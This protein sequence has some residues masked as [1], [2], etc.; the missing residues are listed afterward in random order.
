M[1]IIKATYSCALHGL[2]DRQHHQYWHMVSP[3]LWSPGEGRR[4][5]HLQPSLR[6]EGWVLLTRACLSLNPSKLLTKPLS[7]QCTVHVSAK[8]TPDVSSY[9]SVVVWI[10]VWPPREVSTWHSVLQENHLSTAYRQLRWGDVMSAGSQAYSRLQVSVRIWAEPH[11]LY[12]DI[13]QRKSYLKKLCIFYTYSNAKAIIHYEEKVTNQE[14][15]QRRK[16]Y[17][18][19]EIN[20]GSKSPTIVSVVTDNSCLVHAMFQ[21]LP[22]GLPPLC[23][24]QHVPRH[25]PSSFAWIHPT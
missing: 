18:V 3:F 17:C 19:K 22:Q 16:T 20:L 14:C 24:K 4:N 21:V 9:L 6:D 8:L 1:R 13:P 25:L 5:G 15:N 11:F 7:S 2:G 12:G 10:Q 23:R